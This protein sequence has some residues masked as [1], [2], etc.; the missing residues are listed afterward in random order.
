MSAQI[1]VATMADAA[2]VAA[3]YRPYVEGSAI[4][5]EVDP[6]DEA[7]M[8]RRIG[9]ALE[10]HPWLVCED[11]GRLLGY[12]YGSEH[13]SRA[14][15]RWAADVAVYVHEDGHRRGVGRTL[16]G[17]LFNLLRVQGIINAYA[18]IT[19]PNPKSVGLH[20][21]LGFR[22]VGVYERVGF[23]LGAWRD[24]GWW[25]LALQ[26]RPSVPDAPR[27]WPEVAD[28]DECRTALE[29]GVAAISAPR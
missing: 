23:K 6:P 22:P 27:R 1:R 26:P 7:E 16:Y 21:A 19:L 25:Q 20:E 14:A 11:A 4:S 3:I 13:R 15:Y 24:V 5:F 8:A 2:T 28:R 29:A 18:G 9:K 12:A 17:V 10:T